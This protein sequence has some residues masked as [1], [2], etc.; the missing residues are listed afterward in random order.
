MQFLV[1]FKMQKVIKLR[2]LRERKAPL[3]PHTLLVSLE[4][5]QV[6]HFQKQHYSSNSSSS[7]GGSGA[8]ATMAN[9]ASF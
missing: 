4:Q 2:K 6:M 3:E 8:L 1:T 5:W 7:S 9:S